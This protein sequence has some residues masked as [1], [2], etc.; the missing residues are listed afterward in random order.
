MKR[1]A[2]LVEVA[3]LASDSADFHRHLADLLDEF[4]M[5][6]DPGMLAEEPARL[7]GRFAKG[8]VADAYL[9]AVAVALTREIRTNPPAWAWAADRK[10]PR[11]PGTDNNPHHPPGTD[12]TPPQWTYPRDRQIVGVEFQIILEHSYWA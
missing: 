12:R 6:R 9:A 10:L 11:T 5:R 3:A 1:P 4:R 7:T 8:E 2:S